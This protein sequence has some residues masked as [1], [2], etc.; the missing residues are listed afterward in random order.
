MHGPDTKTAMI[1]KHFAYIIAAAVLAAACGKEAAEPEQSGLNNTEPA[2]EHPHYGEGTLV[3]I[4]A[5]IVREGDD[6]SRAS[7]DSGTGTMSWEAGDAIAVWTGSAFTE[8]TIDPA[9]IGDE[10]PTFNAVLT[11][12]QEVGELAV[13][14][15]SA[16][17][18]YNSG[19]DALG[20]AL[21]A[22]Y[23]TYSGSDTRAVMVAKGTSTVTTGASTSVKEFHFK[24]FG[25]SV[26]LTIKDMNGAASAIT[27]TLPGKKLSGTYNVTLASATEIALEANSTDDEQTVSFTLPDIASR[28]SS[29]VFYLPVPTGSLSG[30]QVKAVTSGGAVLATATLGAGYAAARGDLLAFSGKSA[31]S[32][33]VLGGGMGTEASPLLISSKEDLVALSS[34]VNTSESQAAFRRLYYQ[35][36]AD[37]D[38]STVDNFTPIGQAVDFTGTYDGNNKTISNLKITSTAACV[39][40]FGQIT[41]GATIKDLTI[42]DCDITSTHEY[43]AAIVGSCN[44]NVSGCTVSGSISGT[45]DRTGGIIGHSSNSSNV[46]NCTV[47]DGTT[48]EGKT[49]TGGIAGRARGGSISGCTVHADITGTTYTGGIIGRNANLSVTISDCTVS[50]NAVV[51]GSSQTGGILGGSATDDGNTTVFGISGCIVKAPVSGSSYVGGIAGA[52]CT[53]ENA[54]TRD[55]SLTI[56]DCYC[57]GTITGSSSGIGGILGAKGVGFV[58]IKNCYCCSDITGTISLGGILGYHYSTVEEQQLTIL[59]SSYVNGT[60]EGT[61]KNSSN[62]RLIGGLVGWVRT[63]SQ[64]RIINCY[65]KPVELKGISGENPVNIGGLV[66]YKNSGKAFT[67]NTCYSTVTPSTIK[68]GGEAIADP[69]TFYGGCFGQNTSGSSNHLSYLYWNDAIAGSGTDADNTTYL[70]AGNHCSALSTTAM[71]DG[72]LLANLNAGRAAYNATAESGLEAAEWVAGAG[73]Y[74]TISGLP[75]GD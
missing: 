36:S 41:S 22:S 48:I 31:I 70:V 67:L 19:T 65:A 4:Q 15:Y 55:A 43:T 18:T 33:K 30:L 11:E 71:T 51:T 56:S 39:G 54:A 27:A 47:L 2:V 58:T 12:G 16:S 53:S 61:S 40:L 68:I 14:P 34:F 44:A 10:Y 24:H 45:A 60:I 32:I 1:M 49:A 52:F 17:H 64:P 42:S 29:M 3:S 69:Y 50:E 5:G 63:K 37:I 35:Q 28:T 6:S 9:T 73:G 74:P 7:V 66:G 46:T 38:L 75:T 25:A 8:F 59:N 62:F 72:T 57:S 21:P 23:D 13:Y 26:M 20:I